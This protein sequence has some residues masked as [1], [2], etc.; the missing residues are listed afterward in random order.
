MK[1]D[2]VYLSFIV[3]LFVLLFV[4]S[5]SNQPSSSLL[6]DTQSEIGRY[7]YLPI[8]RGEFG[9]FLDT[10]EGFVYYYDESSKQFRVLDLK[11]AIGD[12]YTK[13]YSELFKELSKAEDPLKRSRIERDLQEV[14][15]RIR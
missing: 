10:K 11:Q 5:A 15:Q 3:V 6:S 9:G 1:K 13:Q 8:A 12:Y 14:K 2:Y 7:Q 4:Q